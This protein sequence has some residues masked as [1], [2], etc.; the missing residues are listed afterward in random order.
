MPRCVGR[1]GVGAIPGHVC[2]DVC[3]GGDGTVAV[4]GEDVSLNVFLLTM[5]LIVFVIGII[6]LIKD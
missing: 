5:A 1:G 6:F 3:A 4:E 2:A